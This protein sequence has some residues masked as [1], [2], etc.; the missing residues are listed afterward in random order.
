MDMESV[1][2]S[3]VGH[4]IVLVFVDIIYLRDNNNKIITSTSLILQGKKTK[5][6]KNT[7]R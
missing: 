5:R 2:G 7:Y 4:E 6:K 1:G 3:E